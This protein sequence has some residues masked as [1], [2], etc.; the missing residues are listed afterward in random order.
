MI[1]STLTTVSRR[2]DLFTGYNAICVRAYFTWPAQFK[3]KGTSWF[4]F[5]VARSFNP[6]SQTTYMKRIYFLLLSAFISALTIA[7]ET[8]TTKVDVNL[9]KDGASAFPWIW[10]IGGV[11]FVLLLVA[12]LS[13]RGGTDRVIEK[14]TIIKD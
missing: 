2:D 3:L 7:Q 6:L 9:N 8:T 14:K 12:L 4:P 13:G 1:I 5:F 11:V 10:V